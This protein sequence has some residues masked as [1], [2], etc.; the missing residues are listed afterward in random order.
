MPT[1]YQ[2][3]GVHSKAETGTI[4]AAYLKLIKRHH[5]DR[6]DSGA[7]HVEI[8]EINLAYSVLRDGAKRADY[9]AQLLRQLMRSRPMAPGRY[10]PPARLV[11]PW[12]GMRRRRSLFALRI[13]A[14]AAAVAFVAIPSDRFIDAND[15]SGG[16]ETDATAFASAPYPAKSPDFEPPGV[17]ELDSGIDDVVAIAL[18][19]PLDDAHETSVRCFQ[20]ARSMRQRNAVDRCVAFDLAISYWQ[21]GGFGQA[22]ERLYF[23]RTAMKRRHGR[24]LAAH[25]PLNADERLQA[26]DVAT[27]GALVD[28]VKANQARQREAAH[29]E[30]WSEPDP[31]PAKI[32]EVLLR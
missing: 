27:M 11:S 32:P 18:A 4:R 14:I 31:D 15:R 12:A 3:L 5:P 1:H 13:A 10:P 8:T 17:W 28:A 6:G 22:D 16:G 30:D 23:E 24:A 25:D 9:D 20:D 7:T 2:V 26:L 29:D 19:V 21:D